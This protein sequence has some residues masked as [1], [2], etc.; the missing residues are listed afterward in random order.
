MED[1]GTYQQTDRIVELQLEFNRL[2]IQL[3]E[4]NHAWESAA[5]RLA[6]LDH[7]PS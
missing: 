7:A 1:P 4:L 3:K 5:T 6:S 2:R